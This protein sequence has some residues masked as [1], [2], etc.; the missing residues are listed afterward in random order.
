MPASLGPQVT[1]TV[2]CET[3]PE[4]TESRPLPGHWPGFAF[5]QFSLQILANMTGKLWC[6]LSLCGCFIASEVPHF[7]TCLEFFLNYVFT[8]LPD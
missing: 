4:H 7:P 6:L 3:T 8:P 5:F 1:P 2:C